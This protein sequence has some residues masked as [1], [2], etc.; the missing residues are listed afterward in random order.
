[1]AEDCNGSFLNYCVSLIRGHILG[2]LK[3]PFSVMRIS[4]FGP[5]IFFISLNLV[6]KITRL[7]ILLLESMQRLLAFKCLALPESFLIFPF[8]N[9][10]DRWECASPG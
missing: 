2:T 4:V 6:Q 8:I 1:M 3:W 9:V 5:F 10:T 7:D